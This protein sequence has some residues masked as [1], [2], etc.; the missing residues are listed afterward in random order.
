M[1]DDTNAPGAGA[2]TLTD[3]HPPRE[4]LFRAWQPGVELV[5]EEGDGVAPAT[6]RM[7][8]HFTKFNEWTEINSIF[9]GRFLER[10]APG[11]FSKTI[12]ENMG[13]MRALF[14][15]GMDPVVGDKPLGPIEVLREDDVGPWYEVPLLD[16]L[17]PRQ[18]AAW[19]RGWVVRGV[20]PVRVMKEEF[21]QKPNGRNATPRVCRNEPSP[22]R[23]C[24]SSAP[25]PSP[26]TPAPPPGSGRS[27]TSSC[28]AASSTTPTG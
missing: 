14:Q 23:W 1:G 18:R 4:N 25:S 9:E 22:K 6:A 15:H 19:P 8:G 16:A 11:A 13:R 10:F 3:G 21:E 24:A 2:G 28:S 20:V 5:R 26:P 27:P 17:R 12:R 7:V